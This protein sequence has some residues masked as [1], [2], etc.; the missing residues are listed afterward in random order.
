[1]GIK[2]RRAGNG[3]VGKERR[4]WRW[5]EGPEGM[6]EIRR[7]RGAAARGRDTAET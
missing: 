3:W 6:S 7:E 2:A 5:G 1:M 4:V